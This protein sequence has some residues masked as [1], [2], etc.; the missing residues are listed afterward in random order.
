MDHH[1]N[2]RF[3][4]P[5]AHAAPDDDTDDLGASVDD[6]DGPTGKVRRCPALA[7]AVAASLPPHASHRGG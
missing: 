1:A 7:A 2:V 6:A 5:L 4:S 3:G